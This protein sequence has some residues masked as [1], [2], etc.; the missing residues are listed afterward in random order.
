[1]KD[2]QEDKLFLIKN[3]IQDC[4]GRHTFFRDR[5]DSSMTEENLFRFSKFQVTIFL[6][7]SLLH[8]IFLFTRAMR[9][10]NL[11]FRKWIFFT[12]TTKVYIVMK[13]RSRT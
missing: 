1:M 7:L 10:S 11:F 9:D 13:G 5:I 2:G 6:F 8:T 3:Q 12:M 4:R